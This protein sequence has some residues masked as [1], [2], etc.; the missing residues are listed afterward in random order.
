M[1]RNIKHL[2]LL[3]FTVLPAVMLAQ[4]DRTVMLEHFTNTNCSNCG[5]RNPGLFTN[6]ETNGEG[7]IHVS[8]YPSRPYPDCK[9]NN[10]NTKEN[11]DRTKFYNLYGSTPQ[12]AIQGEAKNRPNFTSSSLFTPYKGGMSSFDIEVTQTKTSDKTDVS[13]VIT[14]TEDNTVGNL[15]LVALMVEDTVFYKGRNSETEHYNVF[16]KSMAGIEGEAK[17]M[18]VTKNDF[19]TVEYSVNNH[20]DWNVS[21]MYAVAFLQDPMSKEIHQAAVAP[22]MGL[23]TG[24][25]SIDNH[26]ISIYPTLVTDQIT[27]SGF[28]E[29]QSFSIMNLQGQVVKDGI[30]STPTVSLQNIETGVYFLRLNQEVFKILKK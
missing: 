19:I 20:V 23:P 13:I 8:Y 24:I 6:L 28:D 3:T 16:R 25:N 14:A 11:D 4:T 2:L 5:N 26:D 17:A 7:V 12:L 1:Y 27:I 30:L 18:P 22:N 15:N 10:H 21:R 29:G 9:L